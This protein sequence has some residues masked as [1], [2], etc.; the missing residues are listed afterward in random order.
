[1]NAD[2]VSV[3]TTR[4]GFVPCSAMVLIAV[5]A[6]GD[7]W[8]YRT[9]GGLALRAVGFREQAARRNG[10]RVAMVHVRA[11]VVSGLLAAVGGLLL[12]TEVGVGHP[13]VGATY[14]LVSIA[15]A[16]LGGAALSGGR[17]SFTGALLGALFF[18]L[19]NNIMP[20]LGLGA[21]FGSILSGALTLLAILIYAGRLPIGRLRLMLRQRPAPQA[22]VR[23]SA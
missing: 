17:G 9:R 10:V 2:F 5:A 23:T 3:L 18:T 11:Y 4:I 21:A 8:I 14:T 1:V 20:F 7:W 6:A 13:T 22:A 19:I 12:S 16:V 15:A